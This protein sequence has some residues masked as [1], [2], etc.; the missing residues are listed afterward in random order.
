MHFFCANAPSRRIQ[1]T[2]IILRFLLKRQMG[3]AMK[4]QLQNYSLRYFCR[5]VGTISCSSRSVLTFVLCNLF[6][7]AP[8]WCNVEEILFQAYANAE[9]P[10]LK[11]LLTI[12]S[13]FRE[14]VVY[15]VCFKRG[16]HKIFFMKRWKVAHE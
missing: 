6:A 8:L 15:T 4:E 5:S 2:Q 12:S 13:F 14:N 3:M 1:Q 11:L 16:M 7:R 10:N 9:L